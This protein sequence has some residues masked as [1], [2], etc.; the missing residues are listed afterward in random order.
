MAIARCRRTICCSSYGGK[1]NSIRSLELTY[2]GPA[3]RATLDLHP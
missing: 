3:D 1:V 2:A